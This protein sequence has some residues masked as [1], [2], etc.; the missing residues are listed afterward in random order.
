MLC[1]KKLAAEIWRRLR[2]DG[3]SA[4]DATD[5]NPRQIGLAVVHYSGEDD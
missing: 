3:K 4:A 5:V 1:C 2:T